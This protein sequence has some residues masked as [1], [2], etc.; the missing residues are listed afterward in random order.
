MTS[1]HLPLAIQSPDQL[2]LGTDEL[3]RYAEILA[4]TG[5]QAVATGKDT[6]RGHLSGLSECGLA[7]LALV[8]E[9]RRAEATA[10]EDLAGRLEDLLHSTPTVHLTLATMPPSELRAELT[11]WFRETIHPA[12]L[13]AFHANPRLAGGMTVRTTNRVYDWS[14]RTPLLKRTDAFIKLLERA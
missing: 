5:R 1:V 6:G 13:L 7:L 2:Q 12:V 14:F 3:G 10:V 9:K 11:R 8:P 4:R